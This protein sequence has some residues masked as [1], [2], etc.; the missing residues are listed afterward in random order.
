MKTK[1]IYKIKMIEDYIKNFFEK[2]FPSFYL[3]SKEELWEFLREMLQENSKLAASTSNTLLDTELYDFLELGSYEYIKDLTYEN[4][5][6]L[7]YFITSAS[8]ISKNG[9]IFFTGNNSIELSALLGKSK[10]IIVIISYKKLVENDEKAFERINNYV[11]ELKHIDN[12]FDFDR[13]TLK[14]NKQDS[15]KSIEL[16]ILGQEYGY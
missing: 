12:I 11:K 4:I 9:N 6:N 15:D 14:I 10:K 13:Y 7:D 8:A 3:D 16:I 1:D 2:D 5:D